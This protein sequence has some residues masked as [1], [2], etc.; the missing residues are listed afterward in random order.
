MFALTGLV[1]QFR[2]GVAPRD[3]VTFVVV[4]TAIVLATLLAGLAPAL[5]AACITPVTALAEK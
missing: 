1:E 4:T 5:R 2:F 3:P